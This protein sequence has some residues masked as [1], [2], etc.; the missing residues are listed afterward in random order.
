MRAMS[1][2]TEGGATRPHGPRL[3]IAAVVLTATACVAALVFRTPLQSRIWA[4]RLAHATTPAERAAYLGP[5]CN[6][7]ERA[8]WGIA[9]LLAD[10]MP[11]VRQYGALAL[12]HVKTDWARQ[13]LLALLRDPDEPVRRLAAVGLAIQF[14]ERVI[15]TLKQY[16]ETGDDDSAA[17]ACLALERLGTP[18]AV[19][20]LAESAPR[21]ADVAR[22]ADLIDALEGIGTPACVPALIALL[23]DDRPCDLP[24][25]SEEL[26]ARA[27]QGLAAAGYPRQPA[28]LPTTGPRP[29]T[30]AERAAA[31]LAQI[32]GLDLPFSSDA[33]DEERAAAIRQWTQWATGVPDASQ[34]S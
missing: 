5:L 8:R 16:Y 34:P 11:D 25:R 18:A 6:A 26:T 2:Q 17:A 21:P 3:A 30:V 24:P 15:P 19:A 10:R 14:D 20:A 9:A 23:S 7:G 29:H 12:Q 28:S 1:E 22:R 33:P 32:T 4:Y 13:R 27:L 31:A